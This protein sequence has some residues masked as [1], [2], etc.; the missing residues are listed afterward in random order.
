MLVWVVDGCWWRWFASKIYW[1]KF[2]GAVALPPYGV[3]LSLADLACCAAD[4]TLLQ[5]ISEQF[6]H[7]QAR[8][9]DANFVGVN[10]VVH[11]HFWNM[12]FLLLFH[13]FGNVDII[14]RGGRWC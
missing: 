10:V 2:D 8:E 12:F 1:N 6:W 11:I 3:R 9:P 4:V 13:L 14:F 7:I 5:I